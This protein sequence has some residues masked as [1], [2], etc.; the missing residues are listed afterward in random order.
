MQSLT[1]GPLRQSFR[2]DPGAVNGSESVRGP[3]AI[4]A[5]FPADLDECGDDAPP[6]PQYEEVE[7]ANLAP[8]VKPLSRMGTAQS[9]MSPTVQQHILAAANGWATQET[10]TS[11]G[12]ASL[13]TSL[14]QR[15]LLPKLEVSNWSNKSTGKC[16]V[17]LGQH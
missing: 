9:L 8:A 12:V 15:K 7:S 10:F 1:S 3:D 4:E 13:Q 2:V 14:S 17:L 5:L 6:Q 16:T 11:V